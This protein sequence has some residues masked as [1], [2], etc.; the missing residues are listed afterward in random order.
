MKK[1]I[2]YVKYDLIGPEGGF[3]SYN[4]FMALYVK[5]IHFLDYHGLVKRKSNL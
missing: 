5:R 2:V 1:A 3:F 4:E